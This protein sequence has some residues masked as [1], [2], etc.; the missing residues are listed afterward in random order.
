MSDRMNVLFIMTDQQRADHLS[1]YGNQT[2]KT[3]NIDSIA[4]DDG[5]RFSN[6]YCNTPICMPNR[7]NFFTGCYPSVHGT[8]SNGINL[9]PNFTTISDVL[10][11]KGFHTIS[12][13]KTHFNFYARSSIRNVHSMEDLT[14]WMDGETPD[15]FN[16]P[17]YGFE[18]IYLTIG[19]G[20]VIGGHYFNWLRKKNFEMSEKVKNRFLKLNDYFYDT[21][22][23]EELY[24][25]NYITQQTV[26]FLESY[27]EGNYSNKPFFIHCSF[28]DP[29]HPVCPPGKYK[30]LYDPDNISLP[31]NFN[32]SKELLNHSFLGP[33]LKDTRFRQLLPQNIDKETAK[34]FLSLT[35]GSISMIDDGVGKILS[36][37]K[38]TGLDK[39]TMIIFT[40]DHGDLGSDHGLILKGPAHYQGLINIPLLWKIPGITKG[41]TSSSLVSTID[42]TKTLY[43][44]LNIRKKDQPNILQGKDITPIL[45]DPEKEVQNKILIEHDE[46]LAKDKI[47][48]LRTLITKRHRITLY[49]GYK[50]GDIFD[51]EQDPHEQNNLWDNKDLK[52]KMIEELLREIIRL[53]PRQPPRAAFN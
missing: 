50:E 5:M 29:H 43:D 47:I 42:L 12:V 30:D 8:R 35:Y 49:D 41:N 11:E 2:L 52:N 24:P 19:H 20:D 26:N 21:E 31:Q 34:K 13:G 16:V 17:Y 14:L 53:R 27:N 10:R 4:E 32:D 48:R 51:L 46:E 1:C 18:E 3:P 33:H 23:P 25:T 40:S 37:L 39:N 45:K 9:N 6:Y 28:N 38:K 44:L 7:A 36:T 22:L 15:M